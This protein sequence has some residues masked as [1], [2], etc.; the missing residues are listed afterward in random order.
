MLDACRVCTKVRTE[1]VCLTMDLP[2][3]TVRILMRALLASI[4]TCRAER[5]R[6]RRKGSPVAQ[7]VLPSAVIRVGTASVPTYALM[8]TY[9]LPGLWARTC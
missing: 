7:V 5:L 3:T 9:S 1:A 4:F 2:A 6:F 8:R